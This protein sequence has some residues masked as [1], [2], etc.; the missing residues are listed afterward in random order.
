M[1]INFD[2][3][4]P[5]DHAVNGLKQ[6]QQGTIQKDQAIQMAKSGFLTHMGGKLPDFLKGLLQ[7]AKDAAGKIVGGNVIN[8]DNSANQNINS[9]DTNRATDV[10]IGH[11]SRGETAPVASVSS[12]G[13][14]G[15]SQITP[16]MIT[17]YNKLTNSNVTPERLGSDEQLQRQMTSTLVGDIMKSYSEGLQKDWPTGTDKLRKFKQEIQTQF[18]EPI[19]WL[20]GEWVA[21]PNWVSKLDNPTAPGATETVR[22]YITRVGE[23]YKQNNQTV[24]NQ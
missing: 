15:V 21:G 24:L 22:D 9:L 12:A 7:E 17:R 3:F 11:E 10:L 5:F 6:S 18:N 16:I 23:L 2:K 8:I 19:Y 14:I 20:A 1:A 4:N 13:A